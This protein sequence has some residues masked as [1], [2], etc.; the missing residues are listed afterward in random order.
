MRLTLALTMPGYHDW[1]WPDG[2][3]LAHN[4]P[5]GESPSLPEGWEWSDH[6]TVR[7]TDAPIRIS[8]RYQDGYQLFVDARENW[9]GL[10]VHDELVDQILQHIPGTDPEAAQEASAE[11]VFELCAHFARWTMGARTFYVAVSP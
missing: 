5:D 4:V 8:T 7:R 2:S 1:H 9:T 3:V 10:D 6:R 11:F